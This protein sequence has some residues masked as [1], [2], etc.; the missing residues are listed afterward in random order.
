MLGTG[1]SRFFII[2]LFS[3]A[4]VASGETP[5]SKFHQ[6]YY[7]EDAKG[8]FAA[9]A[10]L[11]DEVAADGGV[12]AK[13]RSEAKSR[14]AGCR[15]ELAAA[16]FTRLMPP[17]ALVYAELNRPGEQVNRLMEQLGFSPSGDKIG[18][19][20]GRQ[21]T[22]SPAL[23]KALIGVR[24]IAVALTGFDVQNEK[25][26]GVAII[27]PGDME[28]IRGLVETALPAAAEPSSPIEGCSTYSIENEVLVTLTSRLILVSPAR[29]EIE[30]VIARLRGE[31]D[32]SLATSD[33]LAAAMQKRNDAL[34]FFCVNFEPIL[35]L[36]NAG[37]AVGGGQKRE[38][39][40]AQ[41]ILDLNSLRSLVGRAGVTSDGLAFDVTLELKEGHRNLAFNFLRL[42]ALD[43]N[44]LT[45]VPSGALGFV[46]LAVNETGSRYAA[47]KAD[48]DDTPPISFLDFGREIFANVLSLSAFVIPA[49]DFEVDGDKLPAPALVMTV[50]DLD[51][52]RALWSQML[53]IAS[54]ASGAANSLEPAVIKIEGVDAAKFD[55]PEG[56]GL[57]L[58]AHE[59]RLILS[60]SRQ[61][62]TSSL[63]TLRGGKNVLQDEAFSKCLSAL[64][65]D[66]TVG[67]FVHVGRAAQFARRFMDE[68]DLRQAGE[69]L[70][71]L[72]NTAASLSMIHSSTTFQFSMTVTGLPRLAPALSRLIARERQSERLSAATLRVVDDELTKLRE[73]FE[74]A[75]AS[76][77]SAAEALAESIAG[78][79]QDDVTEMNNF[80]WRLLTEELYAG[81]FNALALRL[82]LKT[83]ELSGGKN[84]MFVDTL[85]RARFELG[86]VDAAIELQRRALELCD[87]QRRR[88]EVEEALARYEAAQQARRAANSG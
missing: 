71:T 19:E 2:G 52:S 18:G 79:I 87:N 27:H 56:V 59:G 6:A 11:Y 28:L 74:A 38:L 12:D 15:E 32:E 1:R 39:A 51:K 53:G 45:L 83:N 16:D 68:E 9:A 30:G 76:D 31:E 40:I 48:G 47:G 10:K 41:A 26:S 54:L 55:L 3:L 35:P 88:T 77:P 4:V 60:P 72:T 23:I 44:A 78:A 13:T 66:S 5:Q 84:W 58:A 65:P 86:E 25:P 21:I 8:D 49:D 22:L 36:L 63:A 73:Q 37:L 57:Y 29:S 81:K 70:D 17:T 24:G 50:N 34:L 14:A 46:A 20:D 7:L 82:A 67:A 85:A 61:A 43:K 42:P 75:A 64:N 33:T 69:I 62:L 80:A